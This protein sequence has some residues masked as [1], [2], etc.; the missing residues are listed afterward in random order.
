MNS[1]SSI[2]YRAIVAPFYKQ[3]AGAVYFL[4]FVLLGIQP[5]FKQALQTH[6]YIIR[7]I[8]D[9]LAALG[10][11]VVLCLL[12]S[13]K[14]ISFYASRVAKNEYLFLQ[15][16]NSIPFSKRIPGF[17]FISVLLLSPVLLYTSGIV[18]VCIWSQQ[19][20]NAITPVLFAILLL[21]LTMLSFDRLNR[22][23]ALFKEISLPR[24]VALPARLWPF[25]LRYIFHEQFLALV[26]LKL[27]SFC[28]LY[29]FVITDA[30]VFEGRMLWLIYTLVLA[31]HCVIIYKT[32]YFLEH[33]L[34]FYRTLPLYLPRILAAFLL[35]YLVLLLPEFWALRALAL[36]HHQVYEYICM[37][38]AG[39]AILSLL[40]VLLYTDD[41]KI[42]GYL[43]LV[44]L[45]WILFFFLSFAENKWLLPVIA[46]TGAGIVFYTSFRNFEKRATIER[47][48]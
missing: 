46:L 39:P 23:P 26:I 35:C 17:A 29:F 12:Y 28:C 16:I 13:L 47:L 36:Q 20:P 11:F 24:L 10:I 22:N 43:S 48:E 9:N 45:V 19:W 42:D 21:V 18:V 31:G 2:L 14:C 1:I 34:S 33:K 3:I 41:F 5:G 7:S 25:M 37:L 27:V 4:F 32:F 15:V 6:Y 30:R 44:F 38:L 8:A 40:H